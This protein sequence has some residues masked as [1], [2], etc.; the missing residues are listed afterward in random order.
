MPVEIGGSNALTPLCVAGE[1]GFPVLDADLLGRALPKIQMI[2]T[3]IFGIMPSKAYICDPQTGASSIIQCTSYEE[4]E[5]KA[6]AIAAQHQST[7]AVLIPIVLSGNQ[8]KLAAVHH[9]ISLAISIG[10]SD[11][12]QELCNVIKGNIQCTGRISKWD[13]TVQNGFLLGRLH[14]RSEHDEIFEIHV[15]NEYL[16]LTKNNLKVA[17]APKIISLLHPENLQPILSDQIEEG[18]QIICV[19]CKGPDL[20]HLPKG[21]E[22]IK[23]AKIL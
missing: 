9:T 23:S 19:T 12:L 6:R 13:Y 10:S 2:S 16:K 5:S 17:E 1:A 4:L 18:Q 22:I 15:Q 14:I 8:A 21:L 3:N 7:A 20:W 11:S